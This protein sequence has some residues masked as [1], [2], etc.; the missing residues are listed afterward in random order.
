MA[1]RSCF[2]EAI[3]RRVLLCGLQ[4][5]HTHSHSD[6]LTTNVD[7]NLPK[8]G[9]VIGILSHL[10]VQHSDCLEQ[11]MWSLIEACTVIHLA[12]GLLVCMYKM[13]C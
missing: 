13:K 4:D 6:V 5:F 2:P 12:F 10:A 7:P 9:S 3:I 1:C 11:G 8:M